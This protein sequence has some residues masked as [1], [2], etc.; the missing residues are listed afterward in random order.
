MDDNLLVLKPWYKMKY[1]IS[2]QVILVVAAF[3]FYVSGYDECVIV[4]LDLNKI[5]DI[6]ADADMII[7]QG[8]KGEE[9]IC[10]YEN[11]STADLDIEV[12]KKII[13]SSMLS[14]RD[15]VSGH[16]KAIVGPVVARD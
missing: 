12:T 13:L 11:G 4:G 9:F 15:I 14:N 7:A 6:E 3:D 8:N 2:A 10:E 5:K 16:D 1:L